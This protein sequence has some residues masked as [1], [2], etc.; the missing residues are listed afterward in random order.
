[1]CNDSNELGREQG[2]NSRADGV[3]LLVCGGR[4]FDA[5]AWV[6][7][8]LDRVMARVSVSTLIT[9]GATGADALA[10]DWAFSRGI[11]HVCFKASWSDGKGGVRRAAGPERNARMLAEGKPN[12]AVAFPGG[13]GTADMVRRLESAGIKTWHPLRWDTQM[14]IPDARIPQ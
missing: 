3:R 5:R 8:A 4:D 9:G 12:I 7:E 11:P 2:A 1:M 6:Y 14:P 13:R 10:A